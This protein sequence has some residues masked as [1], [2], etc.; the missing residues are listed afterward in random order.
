MPLYEHIVLKAR[1]LNIRGAT[2]IRGIM[3]FDIH[4]RIL[5]AELLSLSLDLPII[6][7]FIDTE[8]NLN[9]FMPFLDETIEEGL[10]TLE[11]VKVIKYR[12]DKNKL[13]P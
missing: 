4:S 10:V 13:V 8:E 12:N 6:I 7:E 9:K 5:K 3:G 1:E 2:V 11:K